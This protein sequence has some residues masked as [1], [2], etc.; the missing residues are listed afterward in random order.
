MLIVAF[1]ATSKGGKEIGINRHPKTFTKEAQMA[2]QASQTSQ[3]PPKRKFQE[4]TGQWLW[5]IPELRAIF[6]TLKRKETEQA[7]AKKS[8]RPV[9]QP[10]R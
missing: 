2:E 1:V 8:H 5:D 9:G 7:M 4:R 6:G 10:S 3:T